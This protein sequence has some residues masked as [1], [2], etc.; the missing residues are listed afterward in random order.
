M[1]AVARRKSGPAIASDV[2]PRQAKSSAPSGSE[3]M[4]NTRGNGGLGAAAQRLHSILDRCVWRGSSGAEAHWL[5]CGLSLLSGS[6]HTLKTL[7]S[8]F[9]TG[10]EH[11]GHRDILNVMANLGYHVTKQ[12]G[13]LKSIPAKR[14]PVLFIPRSGPA[15]VLFE[16]RDTHELMIFR[17]PGTVEPLGKTVLGAGSFWSFK[18]NSDTQPLSKTRRGHTGHT[19]FRALLSKFKG[20]GKSL[21]LLSLALAA[22]G[23]MLPVFT[24]QI[25]SEVIALGSLQPLPYFIAGIIIII[26]LEVGLVLI[27]S[28]ILAWVASRIDFL[29]SISSFDRILKVRPA[30][31]ERAAVTDQAARLRTVE[32][33]REFITGPMFIALLDVPVTIA[34]LCVIG[35]L[36]GWLVVVPIVGICCH[37][38]LFML[39]RRRVKVITSIAADETTEMQRVA[40]ETFE[41][42][43]AIR[44]AG[45]HYLWAAKLIRNARREQKSQLLLRLLGALGEAGSTFIFTVSTILLLAGGAQLTWVD[46]LASGGLLAIT[47]LGF[48]ALGP[49]HVLCLSTQ[50]IEQLRNSINQLNTLL[51]IPLEHDE[52]RE[53]AQVSRIGGEVSFLNT[54]FRNG[55][56]RPVFV[57][58]EMDIEPGEVIGVTGANGSGKTTILKIL[59][60]MVDFSLGAVRLDRVDIRQLPVDE[61]RS[62]ISYV[63]QSPRLFAGTLRDNLLLIDPLATDARIEK[64]MDIVGLRE[65][66]VSLPDYL[67]HLVGVDGDDSLSTEFRFKFAFAQAILT[68][69]NLLLIDEIPN[70]LLDTEVGTVMKNLIASVKGKRTVIFVSHRSDFLK[71][72]DRVIALRYGKI[73]IISKPQSVLENAA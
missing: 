54:G 16:N 59:Q 17:A 71:L 63:P 64:I 18:A 56:T 36:A 51:D 20:V 67:D 13:P 33:V 50:R 34:A 25:Y 43:R 5:F 73:P 48:R 4:A 7:I 31:S 26:V 37:I 53:Y 45:L 22:A 57:G 6:N 42:N 55:D 69:S 24:I 35:F 30:V 21:V 8:A 38:G 11:F 62:R 46:E 2:P 60:G 10:A 70:G 47:I 66:I 68:D 41:K 12:R 61:I 9:P 14:F 52:E 27:R 28:R 49:F 65:D 19:W 15:A 23:I 3:D 1:T 40:I 44:Q 58:L 39:L 32:S 29:A 72:A